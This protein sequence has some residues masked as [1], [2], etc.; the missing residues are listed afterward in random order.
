MIF[1]KA[2][3]IIFKI[4]TT[5]TINNSSRMAEIIHKI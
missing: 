1:L 4:P 2:S 5:N 3:Y